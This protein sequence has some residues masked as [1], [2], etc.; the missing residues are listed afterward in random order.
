MYEFWWGHKYSDHSNWT[1]GYFIKYLFFLFFF[2]FIKVFECFSF[3][4]CFIEKF[5]VKVFNLT[6]A[7]T[8][9]KFVL[10]AS[11]PW[12]YGN[13][14]LHEILGNKQHH[15]FLLRLAGSLA[16]EPY[17]QRDGHSDSAKESWGFLLLPNLCEPH[18]FPFSTS[19]QRLPKGNLSPQPLPA[20]KRTI[21]I[22]I[23]QNRRDSLKV[24]YYVWTLLFNCSYLPPCCL[25]KL[26]PNMEHISKP[27]R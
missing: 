2:F 24:S 23:S 20:R 26:S 3:F 25:T 7:K 10:P 18:S 12:V 19:F 15:L 8:M 9:R 13:W 14:F 17:M 21:V 11:D 6:Q 22:V 1:L 27:Q 4:I 5:Y 16:A